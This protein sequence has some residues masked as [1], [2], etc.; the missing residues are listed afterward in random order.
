MTLKD[1]G[2]ILDILSGAYQNFRGGENT[3]KVWY[4][5]FKGYDVRIVDAAVKSFIFSDEKGFPP[6]P[7]QIMEKLPKRGPRSIRSQG[8]QRELQS[9]YKK[10]V[11]L[12]RANNIP[13]TWEEAKLYGL[14]A[15]QYRRMEDD[16]GINMEDWLWN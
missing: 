7:G 8:E 2:T 6:S 4:E 10:L 3:L 12:R 11:V 16:A 13:A 5:I 9:R 14:T 1:T 15:A